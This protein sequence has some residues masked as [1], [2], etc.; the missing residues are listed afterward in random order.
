MKPRHSAPA[1]ADA[2]R[3]ARGGGRRV[4]LGKLTLCLNKAHLEPD[5]VNAHV[6]ARMGRNESG[7]LRIE[8]IDVDLTPCFPGADASRFD[9][10]KALYEDFCIVT[11]S[12]RHGIPVNVHVAR[13][14]EE[15]KRCA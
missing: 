4:S 3:P 11:E 10:C 8:A 13:C 7:R 9:R 14:G 15:L 2:C 5:A 1:R 12:V 6:T